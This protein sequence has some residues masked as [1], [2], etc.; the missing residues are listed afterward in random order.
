MYGAVLLVTLGSVLA[1]GPA[2]WGQTGRNIPLPP[3]A[4]SYFEL[5][6]NQPTGGSFAVPAAAVVSPAPV[7]APALLLVRL[8]A[9]ARLTIDGAPTRSPGESRL[10]VSPPLQPGRSF[11]YLLRAEAVRDGKKVA[12]NQDVLVRA[13]QES[14]VTLTF[15][16]ARVAGK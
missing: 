12:M 6:M 8:P 14:E 5:T 11:V 1:Q 10:F 16:A 9:D 4:N 3:V 13:G 7:P 15:P 2:E